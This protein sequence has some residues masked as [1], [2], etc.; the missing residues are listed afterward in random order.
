[1]RNVTCVILRFCV[2]YGRSKKNET[3]KY[4]EQLLVRSPPA[5]KR[6]MEPEQK[7][8]FFFEKVAPRCA[9]ARNES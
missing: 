1:M 7:K 5:K 2:T 8:M 6:E 4:I 3:K 9:V